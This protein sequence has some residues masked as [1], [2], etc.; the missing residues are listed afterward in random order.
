MMTENFRGARTVIRDGVRQWFSDLCAHHPT[1]RF[2]AFSFACHENFQG[3]SMWANSLEALQ[4][5]T[6][7]PEDE[8]YAWNPGQWSYSAPFDDAWEDIPKYDSEEHMHVD[9]VVLRYRATCLGAT[10]AALNDLA[11]E[12]FWM[13][14][15]VP[16][17]VYVTIWDSAE[18]K[19]LAP[20]SV[21]RI[22]PP[23][24]FQDH[25]LEPHLWL[26][27]IFSPEKPRRA[28]RRDEPGRLATAFQELFKNPF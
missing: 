6:E 26:G 11:D 19:W 23:Q 28:R 15:P 27:D 21:R 12:G 17:L 10:I 14:Q 2:Y 24:T 1:E 13:R 8:E 4:A 7:E 18:N 5:K 22:N 16:V 20:E 3:A 9:D 25:P